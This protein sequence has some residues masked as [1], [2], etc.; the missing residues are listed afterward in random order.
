M[1]C[2][3]VCV[4]GWIR[5]AGGMHLSRVSAA[6]M[7]LVC[8]DLRVWISSRWPYCLATL[9]FVSIPYIL[10]ALYPYTTHIHTLYYTYIIL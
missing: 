10:F 9:F 5:M 3:K 2:H 8:M 1:Y 4:D 6:V 7:H